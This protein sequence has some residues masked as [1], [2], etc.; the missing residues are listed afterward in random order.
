MSPT[1]DWIQVG[2]VSSEAGPFFHIA[3]FP[4]TVADFEEFVAAKGY[5][6][7]EF[8]SDRGWAWRTTQKLTTPAYW[9]DPQYHKPNYPVTGI[10]FW[11]AEAFAN[12]AG[13]RLPTE[14]EWRFI[15]SNA[16][17]TRFPWGDDDAEIAATKA[18]LSFFGVYRRNGLTNVESFPAGRNKIGVWDLIGNTSEWCLPCKSQTPDTAVLCGGCFWH[19]PATVDVFYRDAV[20]R[21]VRDNQTGIRLVREGRSGSPCP[22]VNPDTFPLAICPKSQSRKPIARPT[23]PFRQE[24][25]PDSFRAEQWELK[26][27]GEGISPKSFSLIDFAKVLPRTELRG[28]FVCVCGWA[29]IN[30]ATGVLL[31][32]LLDA[33]EYKGPIEGRYVLQ[34]SL[35]GPA[36]KIYESCINLS[37]AINHDALLCDE[38]DGQTLTKELGW[39][40]RLIDF[41]LYAYK[42]VKCI[43][44]I[45]ITSQFV[46]GWWELEKGYDPA[47]TIQPKSVMVIGSNPYKLEI[48]QPWHER[49]R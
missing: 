33:A 1:F 2:P 12:F 26:L 16:G 49:R 23:R 30:S 24:G 19:D 20:V 34:R 4:V 10:C 11:E 6:C 28:L 47:G 36:G 40:L 5:H 15:A 44:E 7:R 9:N 18:N 39:P 31:R 41:H 22:T 43:A 46:P 48:S 21:T 42:A 27:H 35:R 8:W 38:L 29:E 45:V 13:A 37:D 32:D 3:A 17:T 25:I 14:E